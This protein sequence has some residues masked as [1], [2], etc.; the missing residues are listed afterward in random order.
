MIGPNGAGKTTLLSILAGIVR[1]DQGGVERAERATSAGCRSR[2][3]STGGSRSARTCACSRASRRSTTSRGRSSEMLSQTGLERAPRRPGLQPLRA[4]TSSGSTS[5]SAC[6]AA[7]RCCCSMS[8]APA[9]TRASGRLWEFVSGLARRRHD[10][11][12]LDPPHPG[13]R[14]LRGPPAGSRRRRGPL[15]RHPRPAAPRRGERRPGRDGATSR[16]P[17]S[18]SSPTG[19][20]DVRWLLLKDLQILRRSPLLTSL[21]VIYPIVLARAD[22]LRALARAGEAEGRLPQP[23]PRRARR[24]PSGVRRST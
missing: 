12:L 7:R 4:A 8:P 15:R 14:A 11:D 23:G 17:S 9:S 18:T 24:S 20:T 21:L 1:A 10:G 2:P 22:R 6:C 3:P 19:G 5:P 13:G 16:P